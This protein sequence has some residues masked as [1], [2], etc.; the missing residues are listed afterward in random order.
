MR[1]AAALLC[2]VFLASTAAAAAAEISCDN[3]NSVA[4]VNAILQGSCHLSVLCKARQ[5]TV[6]E[7]VESFRQGQMSVQHC[8]STLKGI[9]ESEKTQGELR[10]RPPSQRPGSGG[11]G[12]DIIFF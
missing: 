8:S 5:R 11:G 3:E 10:Q 12:G 9:Y 1:A 7:S 6:K 4:Q 2:C